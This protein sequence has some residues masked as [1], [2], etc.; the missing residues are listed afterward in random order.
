M[1]HPEFL[2]GVLAFMARPKLAKAGF[3]FPFTIGFAGLCFFVVEWG[4]RNYI[5][6]AL[7][8]LI[9]GFSN[10]SDK[11]SG[12]LKS[13]GAIGD[14]S[15]SVYLIHP[16]VFLVV[17]ALVS[18]VTPPIWAEEPIRAGCFVFILSVSLASW[19]CFEAPVIGF[20]NMLA[21]RR[22]KR[23]IAN[24][25]KGPQLQTGGATEQRISI[26]PLAPAIRMMARNAGGDLGQ[27]RCRYSE[28]EL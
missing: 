25:N 10:I 16:L 7:F 8:F 19:K 15:Y 20:G 2:A 6:I 26:K 4:G 1:F 14:A 13:I 11:R 3:W 9:A 23:D 17:S 18:K 27:K 22:V 28:R 5:P 21:S 12:W 24:A